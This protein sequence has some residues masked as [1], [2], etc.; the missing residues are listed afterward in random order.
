[1]YL[2][3]SIQ[4]KTRV[5]QS[6]FGDGEAVG[7]KSLQQQWECLWRS[8][9]AEKHRVHVIPVFPKDRTGQR[10]HSFAALCY[11]VMGL[12]ICPP[13]VQATTR[14]P[15]SFTGRRSNRVRKLCLLGVFRALMVHSTSSSSNLRRNNKQA[16]STRAQEID[17]GRG[18]DSTDPHQP[19]GKS[20]WQTGS[21]QESKKACPHVA[22]TTLV[23]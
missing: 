9:G 2:F 16:F 15:F 22:F 19:I 18:G 10:R 8:A 17:K 6:H 14:L 12:R 13:G 20:S 4:K 7:Q 23:N 1:M 21:N 5:Q 3:A 11:K